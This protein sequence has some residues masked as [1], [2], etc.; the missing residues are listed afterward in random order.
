MPEKVW[1]FDTVTLSNFLLADSAALLKERYGNRCIVTREVHNELVSGIPLYKALQQIDRLI[2]S[3]IIKVVAL[4]ETEHRTYLELTRNLGKGEASCIAYAKH[5]SA[6]VA[7]DD[8]A[9]RNQCLRMNI[10]TTGTIGIL[11]ASVLDGTI[12]PNT[13]DDILGRM[14]STGFYSPVQKISNI[15]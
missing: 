9:A 13:A 1:V 3:G 5:Q 10:P 12:E 6:I 11:K 4:T 14:I 8:R 2:E 7:T 15:L